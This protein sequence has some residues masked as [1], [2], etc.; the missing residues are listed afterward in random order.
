MKNYL[1][2]TTLVSKAVLLTTMFSSGGVFA[3][4]L[5]DA[6]KAGT[7]GGSVNIRYENVEDERPNL[8]DN[9]AEALT[10]RFTLHYKSAEFYKTH[11]FVEFENVTA[12]LDDDEYFDGPNGGSGAG[13]AT[14]F[15]AIIDPEGTEVNQAYA[16]FKP[17]PNTEIKVGRQIIT[18]RKAPFHRFLG[19]I[20]WRQ[21]WQTQDAI[22]ITNTSLPDT[23]ILAGYIWNNNFINGQDRD[24]E[25]PIFNV[26]YS[27]LKYAKLEGYYY[28]LNFTNDPFAVDGRQLGTTTAGFRVNGA[29]PVTEF[30][31]AVYAG[32]FA[33]QSESDDAP[34][35]YDAN[36]YLAE[37]GFKF[38]FKDSFV[39]SLLAKVSY[40]VLE[41]DED[42]GIAF[43]TPMGTNHAYQGWADNFLATPGT[44]I[45]DTYF[46]VVATGAYDTKLILSYHMLDPENDTGFDEY[47]DEFDVWFT[48]TWNKKYTLGLKYADYSGDGDGT[49]GNPRST[50]L[51]KFWAYFSLKF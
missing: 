28:D 47:G 26:Q 33:T 38:G 45:E 9:E 34:T 10:G 42:A 19:T 21:N 39:K 46:T 40:E 32:E 36:Y 2:K 8:I 6:L 1:Y 35:D 25:S 51:T 43:R 12:L 22:T 17:F 24:Q 29:V 48:K 5:V 27:G 18:P 30:A 3:D 7:F 16:A 13:G 4:D 15:P 50:D 11:F 31:K 14:G 37:G 23:K 20:L 41:A 49:N 44:G